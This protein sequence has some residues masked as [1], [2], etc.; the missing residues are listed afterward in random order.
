MN[1]VATKACAKRTD[2]VDI[3]MTHPSR[4]E[5]HQRLAH[6]IDAHVYLA[7]RPRRRPTARPAASID[8]QIRCRR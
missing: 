3:E 2:M 1:C 5:R 6:R 8:L 4:L 7:R